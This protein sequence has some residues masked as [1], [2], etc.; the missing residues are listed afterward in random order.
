MLDVFGFRYGNQIQNYW[1][2]MSSNCLCLALCRSPAI[3]VIE[4]NKW[5][6]VF[7]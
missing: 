4:K 1:S 7:T 2:M 5:Y 3:F 6:P